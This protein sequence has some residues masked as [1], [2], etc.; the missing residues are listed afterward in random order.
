MKASHWWLK[1]YLFGTGILAATALHIGS[2]FLAHGSTQPLP[3]TVYNAAIVPDFSQITFGNLPPINSSGSI[4]VPAVVETDIGY[5][6]NRSWNVGDPAPSY[7]MLGDFQEAFALENFTLQDIGSIT[8]QNTENASLEEFGLFKDQTLASLV[9]AMPSL[10]ERRVQEVPPVAAMLAHHF[11]GQFIRSNRKIAGLVRRPQFAE[12]DFAEVDLSNYQVQDIPDLAITPLSQFQSWQEQRIE[13]IPGLAQ[14]PF[15]QFPIPPTVDGGTVA[16]VDVVFSNAEGYAYRSVSGSNKEGYNVPCDGNCSNI[17]LAGIAGV[18]N[19][20][21][22]INGQSQ[23]VEGGEGILGNLFGGKEPTGRNPY[24][25]SF[26]QVVWEVNEA[27]GTVDT[28]MF[29]RFCKRTAFVDLGCTPY[30]IGPVPFLSYSE[31]DWIYLGF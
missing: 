30:A 3:T 6:P 16:E 21:Q 5:N 9:E 11:N 8:G 17:E 13:E 19:G 27:N 20:E 15:D 7:L 18:G 10:L 14:V 1:A 31:K 29:F 12:L 22:W 4:E 23:E 24:G 2:N 26:K 25:M 28:A